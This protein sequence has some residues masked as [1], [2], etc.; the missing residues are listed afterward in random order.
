MSRAV[1]ARVALLGIFLLVGPAVAGCTSDNSGAVN[2]D[3]PD[4]GVT[5]PNA[6]DVADF[7]ATVACMR[8]RGWEIVVDDNSD[9]TFGFG[10]PG[11]SEDQFTAYTAD[12]EDC[13]RLN[14][15]IKSLDDYTDEEWETAY[16]KTVESAECLRGQGYDIPATP[17]FQAWKESYYAGDGS[18]QWVP[19]GFVPVPSMSGDE[20]RALEAICPQVGLG[21]P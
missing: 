19:W 14:S 15:H 11:I 5:A 20:A 9:G 3:E 1:L 13:T 6:Q 7:E 4:E 10:A 12:V 21:L 16:D 2:P 18:Q 8:D 17:S